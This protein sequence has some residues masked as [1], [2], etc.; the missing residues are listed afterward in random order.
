METPL[1]ND[2]SKA[3]FS[4][5]VGSRLRSFK[6]DWLI[7]KCSQNVLNIITNGYVLP[8]R[9]KPNLIRFPLI[10]SEYKAQ[11]KDQALATCI[12]SLLSKN[13]IERVENVKS[14]GFYSRLFLVPK[15]HQRWRPVID[16]SRLNTFLHVEK[17]KMETPESIRTSLVPGE[18]VSSIDLSDAYLHIP[19]HPNSRKYLRFCYKAQVFQ[20]TS[21]PFGLATAPQVFTMIVKEVKLMALSRGLR[22]HQY[23]DDWL[24]R[25]QSQEESQRDTQAVVDLTQS[26][27][28]I[29][30]QEKSELKPTQV[31]SFVGYEYHLD[32]ALVRPT[33]ERWLKLQD[34]ILRLKSKRVLTARCLMSLI[35][36]LASTE[37]MV[38]EG[39]LHMRPFQFHLKEHWR[40]PQSL[41][42]LLPWT[43]AIVAHLDWWQNPSNV[44]KG[45]DL[46]PKDHSIQ[47]FTDASN[48]G[49]GAHLDQ[50]STKGLWSEREKRL[51]INVLELK[52]ISLAL[53]DFKDQCQNQTVLV[54]TDNSTVVAYIN[55][56][57]G[58]HSAEM[59]AL[60]WKIMTW[61]HHYHITLKARHIP[62]CLN[63]MADLLSRSNQVQSTEWSL[64][65]QVFKQIC[66]KW[67]TPLHN[68]DLHRLLSSF[69]R[70]RPKSSRN[71]PKWNLSVVLN[72]LTKAPFEPMKDSDLKH[73][74]LKTAF[75]LALASGKRRSE[76]HAWVASKVA[77]LGQWEKVVL[78]PSS[79]FI[80]KNQ[81]AREGSQSVSPV[82]IPALTTIV[83]RQFKEDRTLCPVRALRFYLD[84]TKDLRGS[85]SLLFISFKKGHTSDIRPATLSS[86][87]KQTILLCYKQADKQALDLVQVKAHDIRAFAASKG[88][89]GGVSVDQIMQA[90]H[91]KAHNT[92]TNFYLKDLT[93]SD[94]DN[95]MYLG[96]VVAAQQVLDPSPQTSCPRKEKR[97]GGGGHIRYNQVFRSLSQDLGIPLPSRCYG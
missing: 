28:W 6:R 66:R 7:N 69:H 68:A 17:F 30:N 5:P 72:E 79:D 44:M 4:P 59:C 61:C 32:S 1:R 60:L 87:L 38:P 78:F 90:C 42:N 83:D 88:F 35:G 18:W 96:P 76:I 89:Y 64:H 2:S 37:K 58:T 48:E 16:L 34:L 85:R 73:L 29:I 56:Q 8:F 22:I 74:T 43:E 86:W 77:N 50:N 25:S 65:P 51:H 52:A 82:T 63:V 81:L 14:L 75:L 97:G 41:D 55:K 12:Q 20:F 19:I 11:Q 91:W 10:L 70:D 23:L 36:L 26:L 3:S 95:N 84:R 24:I 54:A 93:W 40:Y 80:A 13:A 15:P 49:W 71:L 31:F 45:A 57:G 92:F 67:F 47:L 21:L 33:H 39:R 46:H 9:S 94:T 53:R 62:G 27:G